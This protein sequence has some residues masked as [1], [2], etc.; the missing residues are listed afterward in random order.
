MHIKICGITNLE[1]ALAAYHA[2]AW[3]L[4]FNFYPPSPRYITKEAA[5]EII[6]QLPPTLITM[7]IFINQP[8]DEIL[9]LKQQIGLTLLQV[10]EDYSCSAQ[11]KQ[12]MVL[13]TRPENTHELPELGPL[14]DY[15][16]ILIDAPKDTSCLMGGT[17]R[18]ANWEVA[19]SLAQRVKLILAG[20]INPDNAV[21]AIQQVQ[22][23]ALD[24]CSGIESS[25]GKK[26]L[27][28]MRQLFEKVKNH[29]QTA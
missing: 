24:I 16:M 17:G 22:P 7:G 4:G 21:A 1:D 2:G 28:L 12:E 27:N 6:K 20:G 18:K 25:P 26:N 11:L 29:V 19:R 15:S 14:K 10:Y 5:A 23:F 13:V 3:A 9:S 8:L